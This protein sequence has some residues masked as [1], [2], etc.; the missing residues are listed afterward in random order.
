MSIKNDETDERI[1]TKY[2]EK[3]RIKNWKKSLEKK[4]QT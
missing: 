4:E 1:W 2:E 3:R